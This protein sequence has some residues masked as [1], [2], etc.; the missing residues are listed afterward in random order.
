MEMDSI[1]PGTALNRLLTALEYGTRKEDRAFTDRM[2]RA[3]DLARR[4]KDRLVAD[5]LAG[6]GFEKFF[7]AVAREAQPFA[8]MLRAVYGFLSQHRATAER[9]ADV[10]RVSGAGARAAFDFDL[11]AFP[12]EIERVLQRVESAA[13]VMRL[14]FGNDAEASGPFAWDG[15]A[16]KELWDAVSAKWDGDF[17]DDGFFRAV[18]YAWRI[19][20]RS[21]P[22]HV[23][24]VEAL[25]DPIMERLRA[26]TET[27]QWQELFA[28]DLQVTNYM[29]GP[30]ER[31]LVQVHAPLQARLNRAQAVAYFRRPLAIDGNAWPAQ[32]ADELFVGRQQQVRWALESMATAVHLWEIRYIRRSYPDRDEW[33]AKKLRTAFERITPAI[34]VSGLLEPLAEQYS[35]KL[36]ALM[37]VDRQTVIETREALIDFFGLPMWKDRWFLYELW[38]LCHTLAIAQSSWPVELQGLKQHRGGVT[39]WHL[40][41]GLASTPVATIAM[42]AKLECWMQR[43]T[44]HPLTG[45]G[46]EPDLR[47]TRATADHSDVFIVEN[48]D[49]RKPRKSKLL[50][51]IERYVTGTT[52]RC[53][54]LINYEAFTGPTHEL[55]KAV[56]GRDVFIVSNFRPARP[57]DGDF[58]SRLQ[59]A[60]A[61]EL[62]VPLPDQQASAVAGR[63]RSDLLTISLDWQREPQDLDLHAW[64]ER[65]SGSH[66]V[67]Y[68]AH[69]DLNQPPGALLGPDAQR[70]PGRETLQLKTQGLVRAVIA[71]HRFTPG[72]LSSAGASVEIHGSTASPVRFDQIAP[73][74]GEWWHVA[75]IDGEDLAIRVFNH[76]AN[77]PPLPV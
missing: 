8:R 3:F 58:E 15:S 49:R 51:I 39:E 10:F 26:L 44:F 55:D 56:P 16:T 6:P 68:S 20:E 41:G 67:S 52:A 19:L 61:A 4:K 17:Y 35:A 59:Q 71:V 30:A 76:L 11:D 23:A 45:A 2:L 25:I 66:H 73:G 24:R 21:D 18:S 54:C 70:A 74:I 42:P 28:P 62:G 29:N 9:R 37:Q 75:E 57:A 48:K 53:V 40:P 13:D 27:L 46:L 5:I 14:K 60:L 47:I 72:V 38:T 22:E 1:P 69:G 36:D 65:A 7:L 63:T 43:K 32:S 12:K 33:L 34:Y 31:L 77:A 50:E 64:I